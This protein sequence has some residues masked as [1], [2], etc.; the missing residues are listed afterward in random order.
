[1]NSGMGGAPRGRRMLRSHDEMSTRVEVL[2]NTLEGE[3]YVRRALVE[4]LVDA[5]GDGPFSSH[6]QALLGAVGDDV[7]FA[8]AL[9]RLRAELAPAPPSS[10][11]RHALGPSA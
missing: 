1:M 10:T 8:T 9:D 5:L 4:E 11:R 3:R 7:A 6:A 2:L